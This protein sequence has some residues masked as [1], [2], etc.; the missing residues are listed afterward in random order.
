[1]VYHITA[2]HCKLSKSANRYFEKWADKVT[3]WLPSR[4]HDTIKLSYFIAWHQNGH[5]YDGSL[6]LSLP[7]QSLFT[8]FQARS[9][10]DAVKKSFSHIIRMLSHYKGRHFSNHSKYPREELPVKYLRIYR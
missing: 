8:H 4:W 1:M 6:A 9:M 3:H 10:Y 5:Y 2:K 7:R